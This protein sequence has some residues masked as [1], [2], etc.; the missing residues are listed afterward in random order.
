MLLAVITFSFLFFS[1]KKMFLMR[2][3]RKTHRGWKTVIF[4]PFLSFKLLGLGVIDLAYRILEISIVKFWGILFLRQDHGKWLSLP[5]LSLS[6]SLSQTCVR[7]WGFKTNTHPPL[8]NHWCILSYL[9][10]PSPG[11]KLATSLFVAANIISP[12]FCLS[13]CL[14]LFWILNLLNKTILFFR[15]H[16]QGHCLIKR[17]LFQFDL[18]VIKTWVDVLIKLLFPDLQYGTMNVITMVKHIFEDINQLRT[19]SGYF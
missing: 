5:L 12:S 8:I 6:L 10:L 11:A 2:G 16:S 17:C 4:N 19:I 3:H 13:V 7:S 18:K 1:S 14:S 9:S 15:S